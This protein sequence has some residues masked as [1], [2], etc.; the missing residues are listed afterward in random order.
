MRLTQ[1]EIDTIKDMVSQNF[2]NPIIYLFGSRVEDNK[3]GGDI[4]LFIISD[5]SNY[6]AKLKVSS[7]LE[8]LLNKPVDVVLHRDFKREIEQ[9]AIKGVKL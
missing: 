7:K 1:K 3:K 6:K 4:D 5:N 9:E 2:I 8:Y